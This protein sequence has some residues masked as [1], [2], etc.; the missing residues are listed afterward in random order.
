MVLSKPRRHDGP[1]QTKLLVTNLPA[2]T[3]RPV[4]DVDRRRWAVELLIKELKGAMG[5]GQH[6]VTKDPL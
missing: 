4:V 6:Q 3:A 2:V 5:S 1:K